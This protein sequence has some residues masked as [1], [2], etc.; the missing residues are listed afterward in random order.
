MLALE[1]RIVSSLLSSP[2]A[3]R[4][5]AA[6]DFVDGALA[7]MPELLRAGLATI[8]VGLTVWTGL[9]RVVGADDSAAAQLTWMEQHPIGL[10]RQWVRALRSLVLLAEQELIEDASS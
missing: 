6:T 1:H 3:E 4:R 9:R 5:A 10:V 2:G 8:T 7:A